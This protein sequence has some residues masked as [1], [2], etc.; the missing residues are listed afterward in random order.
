MGE[1]NYNIKGNKKAVKIRPEDVRTELEDNEESIRKEVLEVCNKYIVMVI[2]HKPNA[3]FE[4]SDK[5]LWNMILYQLE[6]DDELGE[7]K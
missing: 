3:M 5:A 2:F 7:E 4:Y 1:I 6:E